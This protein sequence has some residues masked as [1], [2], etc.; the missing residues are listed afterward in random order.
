M[1]GLYNKIK[2]LAIVISLCVPM[3]VSAQPDFGGG[4][5][6]DTQ[7]TVPLDGG[8]SLLVVAGAGY[9]IKKI[10]ENRKKRKEDSISIQ[11]TTELK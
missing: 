11:D 1:K 2:F 8:I 5:G 4:G 3:Y 7:D 10:K 6:G 9:G